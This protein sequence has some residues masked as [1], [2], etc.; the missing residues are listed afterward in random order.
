MPKAGNARQMT[1]ARCPREASQ[2]D[3]RAR[4][5]TRVD[6]GIRAR[7]SGLGGIQGQTKANPYLRASSGRYC[8]G[9]TQGKAR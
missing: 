6:R 2:A 9:G 3:A 8:V 7:S 4:A 1:S 5:P